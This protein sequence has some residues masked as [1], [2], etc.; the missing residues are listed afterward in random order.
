M[1]SSQVFDAIMKKPIL[2][3]GILMMVIFLYQLNRKGYFGDRYQAESCRSALVM[4]EKRQPSNWKASCDMGNLIVEENFSF[5]LPPKK[6]AE[7][8][9]Q[10]Y[11]QMANSLMFIASNS[12]NESLERTPFVVF[13]LYSEYL[14]ISARVE[15]A[16]LAK[17]S[18]LAMTE[19]DQAN[20]TIA[21]NKRK[22]IAEHLHR[23]VQVQ[24]RLK[25]DLK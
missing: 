25:I 13:K 21:E 5:P 19:K 8:K 23:H 11:T 22:I 6:M 15:G 7:A 2:M 12:L 10:L 3:I 14:D 24:E 20:A 9:V 16:P 1:R 17:M 4:L 18:G